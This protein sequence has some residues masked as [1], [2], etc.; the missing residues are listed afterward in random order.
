MKINNVW[1]LII[2]INMVTTVVVHAIKDGEERKIKYNFVASL[3]AGLFTV[4]LF[5][6]AGL[7]R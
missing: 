1:E 7:F 4:L 5:Y 6:L 2:V 3:W